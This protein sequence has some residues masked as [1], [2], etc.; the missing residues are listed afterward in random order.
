MAAVF[1]PCNNGFIIHVPVE[2]RNCSLMAL[3][4]CPIEKIVFNH[5]LAT[6]AIFLYF[7]F[8]FFKLRVSSEVICNLV[9]KLAFLLEYM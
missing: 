2:A 4:E 5:M 8:T 3:H 6:L 1:R 9:K 7:L